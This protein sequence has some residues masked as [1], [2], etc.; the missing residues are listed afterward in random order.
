MAT[1]CRPTCPCGGGVFEVRLLGMD[2]FATFAD[3]CVETS[4]SFSAPSLLTVLQ[5]CSQNHP[6]K[7]PCHNNISRNSFL[8]LRPHHPHLLP[9]SHPRQNIPPHLPR[10]RPRDLR[11]E[12]NLQPHISTSPHPTTSSQGGKKKKKEKKKH[13][14]PPWAP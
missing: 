11:H 7:I 14:S 4:F 6:C 1:L 8:Q 9:P 3:T 10:R 5:A 12:E 2:L 13:A